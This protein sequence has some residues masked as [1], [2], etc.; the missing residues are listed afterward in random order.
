MPS[1]A[2]QLF[3][4]RDNRTHDIV[5]WLGAL[6]VLVALALEIYS[7]IALKRAFDMADFGVGTG[8][9]LAALGASLGFKASTEPAPGA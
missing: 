2:T 9:L 5:R 8:G 1:I 3:T 6:I 7:V 4:G